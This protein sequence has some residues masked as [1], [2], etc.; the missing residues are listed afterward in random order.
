MLFSQFFENSTDNHKFLMCDVKFPEN[1]A[2][3]LGNQPWWRLRLST[4]TRFLSTTESDL[5]IS[6]YMHL[7]FILTN[8]WLIR[9][10][11][12][13]K[14]WVH[15]SQ[16][17]LR[18]KIVKNVQFFKFLILAKLLLVLKNL[19]SVVELP[20]WWFLLIKSIGAFFLVYAQFYNVLCR[21]LFQ[22]QKGPRLVI[23]TMQ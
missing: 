23:C 12:Y 13:S 16:S 18:R 5:G 14:E 22:R 6:Y 9:K 17:F 19:E 10:G 20:K 1:R 2:M 11:Q 4:S 7:P 21:F 8:I 3:V 15:I